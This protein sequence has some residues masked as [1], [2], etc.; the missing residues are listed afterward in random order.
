M[1]DRT[2]QPD[3]GNDLVLSNDDGSAKIEVNEGGTISVT[4][5]MTTNS[6]IDGVDIATRDGV[7]TS[8]TTTANAALPKAGGTMTGSIGMGDNTFIGISDSEERIEFDAAGD[9]SCLGAKFGVGTS[10]PTYALDVVTTS[11]AEYVASFVNTALPSGQGILIQSANT[12]PGGQELVRVENT[13]LAHTNFEVHSNGNI[14]IGA[15]GAGTLSTDSSGN[16]TASDERLKTK[17]RELKLGLDLVKKLKPT[18]FRWNEES[19]L[20]RKIVQKKTKDE[21]EITEYRGTEHL[22]F[23][24]QE[25]QAVIPEV[26]HS[27]DDP[28][29]PLNYEDR[30]VIA[31]LVKSVQEL[32]E[33]ITA[34]ENAR[35]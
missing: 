13:T 9:I 27:P 3:T 14:R 21:D 25:V 7:L 12:S 18:F 1:A 22:G 15:Y 32:S 24:A 16:I 11:A 8:T 31:L 35:E 33:K 10:S 4:G 6:T 28:D 19:G 23:I 26:S 20:D 2:L 30:G 17:T 29:R 34:L 5:A